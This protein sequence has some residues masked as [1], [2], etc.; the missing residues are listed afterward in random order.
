MEKV[1][2]LSPGMAVDRRWVGGSWQ[3]ATSTTK[4]WRTGG[5]QRLVEGDEAGVGD[6]IRPK[7]RAVSW[8]EPQE[9]E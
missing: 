8:H 2:V 1:A 9:S 6:T 3:K 7:N 5:S 4:K